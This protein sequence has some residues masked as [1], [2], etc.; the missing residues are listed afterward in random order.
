MKR[1][2]ICIL[3]VSPISAKPACALMQLDGAYESTGTQADP[4][5]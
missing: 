5:A 1:T 4:T 2:T 3:S